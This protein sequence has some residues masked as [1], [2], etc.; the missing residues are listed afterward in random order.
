MDN[1]NPLPDGRALTTGRTQMRRAC[2]CVVDDDES[3]R[4][5]LPDLLDHLGYSCQPFTSA[6][7][8]LMG[9]QMRTVD[10]LVLDVTLPG[11]SGPDLHVELLRRGLNV[12]VIFISARF[13]SA[14]ARRL[15]KQ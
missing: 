13:D 7:E 5:S 6:E 9:D 3:V 12:P 14:L 4:E 11:S 15:M 8:F 2:V 1:A 10:C